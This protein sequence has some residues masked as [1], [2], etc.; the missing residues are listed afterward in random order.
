[1]HPSERG[2]IWIQRLSTLLLGATLLYGINGIPEFD[3]DRILATDYVNPLNRWIW[4]GLLALSLPVL[5]RRFQPALRLA[6]ASW[7]LLVLYG[8]FACS[9]FW[10]LDP[11]ASTRRLLL[12]V[13]Q[14]AL[15]IIL[16]SGLRRPPTAH[17][18]LI[19]VCVLAA[20]ADLGAWVLMPG[21]AM[22]DEGFAGLQLQKN[23]TGLMM[24][25][26]C[27]A[28]GTGFFL[29]PERLW[30]LGMVAALLLMG[31]LLL[32]TRS[33]TSQVIT[34]LMVPVIAAIL[35]LAALPSRVA[36]A[37]VVSS[38]AG[39]LGAL[40]LYVA[41]CDV[42]GIDWL[43]PMRG[44]TFTARTDLWSFVLDEIGRRPWF[45]AGYASLWAID[46][47]IQ[48]SLKSDQW[49]GA[50]AAINEGHE[51]YLDLVATT[52]LVGAALAMAVV[53]RTIVLASRAIG[54]ATPSARS[55]RD[56]GMAHPTAVFHLAF[57]IS[58]LAHNFTESN[59]FTNNSV[60]A[61]VLVL[62]ALDLEKSGVAQAEAARARRAVQFRL[63][64]SAMKPSRR[65]RHWAATTAR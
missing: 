4:L 12:S 57:V 33:T 28:A 26:G 46:P 5:L 49:F 58:L 37:V 11:G 10:A 38:L 53:M 55:W 19:L 63:E 17:V 47:A 20:L 23:Q 2:E 6:R 51:G 14:M 40:L 43:L 3:R 54:A 29:R 60:L 9:T 13:V 48:P 45:G 7:P 59:L 24:M 21:Y 18:L 16:L 39:L 36:W 50:L 64:G 35:G 34:L 32:A 31:G 8:Y 56:G 22:T 65:N 27:L 30:R 52:G 61:V 41:W 44:V 1:M 15:L 42:S 25:L 62:V